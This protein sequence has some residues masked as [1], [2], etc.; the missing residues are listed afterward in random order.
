[1]ADFRVLVR[2]ISQ[3][4]ENHPNADRLTIIRM[5]GYVCIANKKEDGSWRYNEGDYVVY[6]PEGAVV[7]EWALKAYGYWNEEEG[8]GIL[9]GAQGN[10]VKAL[11]LRQIFSQGLLFP[12]IANEAGLFLKTENDLVLVTEGQDVA[13]LLGITKFEPP[14]PVAMAGEVCNLHGCTKKYDIDSIQSFPDMF[15]I[16]EPVFVTEKLHGTN[17][18][19]GWIKDLNH[20]ELFGSTGE[21]YVASKGLG[22]QGLVFK[23]NEANANNIYVRALKKLLADGLEEKIKSDIL[24]NNRRSIHIFGEIFGKGIQDL[25]YGLS[26]PELRVFD[27]SLG[28]G[29]LEDDSSMLYHDVGYI[30]IKRRGDT[31]SWF[32]YIS[33]ILGL[34]PVPALYEGPYDPD[35]LVQYRDGKDT[36]SGSH[37]REGIVIRSLYGERHPTYG[38]KRAKWVSPNYLLRKDKNATEYS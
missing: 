25:A 9:S 37:I 27:I 11:R 17:M 15:N 36:I 31:S 23:N 22:G 34:K 14:I 19:I 32:D 16:G 35:I 2:R 13:E 3:P 26:E 6:V 8:K 7:P 24:F 5:D 33:D 1:M 18:Q 29:V 20:P 21:F 4:V 12:V 30:P 38:F 28:C 10:R